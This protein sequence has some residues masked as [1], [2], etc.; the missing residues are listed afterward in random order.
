MGNPTK[1]QIKAFYTL[2]AERVLDAYSKIDEKEWDKKA[3]DHWTAKG[4]LAYTVGTLE[5]EH[6]PVTRAAVAGE[7]LAF[8]A[9]R[10]ETRNP[11]SAAP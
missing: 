11:P 2:T 10:S 8:P 3:S 9:S 5:E 6:L 1:D 7:A 4:H